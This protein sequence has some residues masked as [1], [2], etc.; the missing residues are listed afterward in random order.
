MFFQKKK[1]K[2]AIALAV[3]LAILLVLCA[4]VYLLADSLLGG[5]GQLDQFQTL[6]PEEMETLF[7]EDATVELEA[8]FDHAETVLKGEGVTNILLVGQDKR[9]G[10]TTQR[11]DAM[12]LC[13]INQKTKTLTMTS[14]LRDMWVYIPDHYN[15]RMNLPYQLGGFSLL[16]DTLAYNFGVRAD[17]NVE[18]DFSGFMQAIDAVG[19]V[20]ITLTDAEAKYLNER[21]NWGV[22][23]NKGWTLTEGENLLTGSQALAYSRIRKIGMDFGRTNRQRTVLAALLEKAKTLEL[24][25]IYGLAKQIVP[26]LRTDMSNPQI[27]GLILD[28]IPLLSDLEVVSQR[29]PMNGEYTFANKNGADVIVLTEKQLKANRELLADTMD[30]DE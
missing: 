22:E 11:T 1:K 24:A 28:I 2:L 10:Q 29:I 18:I 21:G 8:A 5:I 4:A 27:L 12:I 19:G 20:T 13:T 25:E 30:N 23:A 26:Q 6:S 7:E 17:Y 15:Q 14:F 9:E 16:N 3:I